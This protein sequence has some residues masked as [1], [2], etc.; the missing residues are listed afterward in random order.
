MSL[1]A[2]WPLRHTDVGAG[3]DPVL[4]AAD[5]TP[6]GLGVVASE[7]GETMADGTATRAGPERFSQ[8]RMASMMV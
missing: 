6:C 8:G 3:F 4:Y 1:A 5:A 7:V 2:P